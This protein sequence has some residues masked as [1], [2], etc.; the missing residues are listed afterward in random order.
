VTSE[1]PAR[2]IEWTGER[3]V[4]W[5]DDV[6]VIYEHLSRYHFAAGPV[7]GRRVVDVGSGEGY[8]AALLATTAAEVLGIELDPASVEHARRAHR[9]PNL[10]F[11][12]GSVLDP[13]SFGDRR[14]DV[15]VCFEVLE[16][17]HEQEVLLEN[18]GR[19]LD[20]EGLLLISTPDRE[21]YSPPGAPP[22]PYHV[23]ELTRDEFAGLL[24]AHFPHVAVWGQWTVCGAR[25][26]SLD[27]TPGTGPGAISVALR[28]G[29]WEVAETPRATYL[30]A[31]AS[32]APLPP[33]PASWELRDH[34]LELAGSV[35]RLLG[36][37]HER[38]AALE[39]EVARL[40]APAPS[41]PPPPG[42]VVPAAT[43]ALRHLGRRGVEVMRRARRRV[44]G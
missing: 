41:G 24:G 39:A 3:C 13:A 42:T 1:A 37:A 27:G 18:I 23:R 14:F 22:N 8:G 6:Q 9:R 31:A 2:L 36:T 43:E 44:S 4:P 11:V 38:I 12:E 25:L 21:V 34:G 19:A 26:E 33:L 40:S 7:T 32:R 15:A 28:D 35:R 17:L 10:D 5:T 30:L 16:H 29:G 20:D